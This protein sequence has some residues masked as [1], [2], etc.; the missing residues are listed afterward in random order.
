ML[1]LPVYQSLGVMCLPQAH[2]DGAAIETSM[3]RGHGGGPGRAGSHTDPGGRLGVGGAG[4]A[5]EGL[6]WASVLKV[7]RRVPYSPTSTE[8]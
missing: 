8:P 5:R 4:K 2:R 1:Q 3:G 6:T 7:L